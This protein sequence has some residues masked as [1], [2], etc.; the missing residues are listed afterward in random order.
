MPRLGNSSTNTAAGS[1]NN[2]TGQL[3]FYGS[4]SYEFDWR[5]HSQD[6]LIQSDGL[7]SKMYIDDLSVTLDK[8]LAYAG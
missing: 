6:A 8:V 2:R 7:R 5:T 3:R 4:I 1:V